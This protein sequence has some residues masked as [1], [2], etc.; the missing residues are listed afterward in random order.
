MDKILMLA[1]MYRC[2]QIC[3]FDDCGSSYYYVPYMHMAS[4]EV[5]QI[6]G[7]AA[8]SKETDPLNRAQ[9]MEPQDPRPDPARMA[10]GPG[11]A[12]GAAL[13]GQGLK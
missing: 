11:R 2:I 13:K 4:L 12:V 10:R 9:R 3:K 7:A 1:G 6:L 8:R 5:G